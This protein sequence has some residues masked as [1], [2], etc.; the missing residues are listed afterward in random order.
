M[1]TGATV[2]QNQKV[3]GIVDPRVVIPPV[4]H[5][6]GLIN[7]LANQFRMAP[8]NASGHLV[9]LPLDA[10]IAGEVQDFRGI[11]ATTCKAPGFTLKVM[12]F[13]SRTSPSI[14]SF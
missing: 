2:A 3:K 13:A 7:P 9:D 4:D 11:G 12:V 6:S 14:T 10:G 8:A 1:T 5:E